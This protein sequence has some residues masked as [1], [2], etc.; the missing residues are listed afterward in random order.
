MISNVDQLI[1]QA[2]LIENE[3]ERVIFVMN[4]FLQNVKYDY[5][6]LLA[7][8]YMQGT[9]SNANFADDKK[10]HLVEVLL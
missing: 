7:D 4:Y 6:Y 10:R 9:I 1:E 5:G 8:G 2:N 3:T